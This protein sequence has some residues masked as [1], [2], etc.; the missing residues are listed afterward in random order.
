M[1]SSL[2]G[3]YTA[4]TTDQVIHDVSKAVQLASN[5]GMEIE[6]LHTALLFLKENPNATIHDALKAGLMDWDL[7]WTKF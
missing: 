4:E 7:E 1:A 2:H 3:T 5:F 6:V